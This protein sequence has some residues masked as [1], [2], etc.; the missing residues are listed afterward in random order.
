MRDN[1]C[2]IVFVEIEDTCPD[3]LRS[4]ADGV[5]DPE[6]IEA[7]GRERYDVTD[8]DVFQQVDDAYEAGDYDQ[9]QELI[10]DWKAQHVAHSSA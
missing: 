1:S 3:E 10:D 8:P 4:T 7:L 2:A 9:A 6:D 5:W